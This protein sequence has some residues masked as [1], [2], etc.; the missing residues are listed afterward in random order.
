M[1]AYQPLDETD[2]PPHLAAPGAASIAALALAPGAGLQTEHLAITLDPA[3][4][5][6][7]FGTRALALCA[8][9]P[10][11]AVVGT[12]QTAPPGAPPAFLYV[13]D[14]RSGAEGAW[15]DCQTLPRANPTRCLPQGVALTRL[16]AQWR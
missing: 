6:G 2:G 12:L 10:R 13:R 15:W 7:S 1:L 8:D 11:C 4:F 5:P 9:R 3:A 14:R 16:L